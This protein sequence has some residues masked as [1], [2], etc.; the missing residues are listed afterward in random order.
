MK[1]TRI[2]CTVALDV[3]SDWYDGLNADRPQDIVAQHVENM[4]DFAAGAFIPPDH[5]TIV[6]VE[7]SEVL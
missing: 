4:I 7:A 5:M 3:D 1:P 6:Y 2:Y